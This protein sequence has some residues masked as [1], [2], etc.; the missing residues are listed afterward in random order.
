MKELDHNNIVKTIGFVIDPPELV[1]ISEYCSKGS[2]MVCRIC[3]TNSINLIN[4]YVV[5]PRYHEF[6]QVVFLNYLK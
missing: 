5:D 2:L 4:E 3:K 1:Y 6:G